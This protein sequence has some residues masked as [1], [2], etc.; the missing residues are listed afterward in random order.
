[1]PEGDTIHYAANRIRPV[2]EGRIPEEIRTPQARHRMDRWPERLAGREVEAVEARGKHLLIRFAGELTIHSHLRMTGSWGVYGVGSP[3]APRAAPRLARD[4]RRGIGGRR[5]R[6]AGPRA[7]ERVAG[8]GR[9]PPEEA[10][11][12]RDRLRTSTSSCSCA[13]CAKTIPTRPIGDALLD[14]R[15]LAGI[16]NLW[17]AESCFAAALDPWRCDGRGERRGGHARPSASPASRWPRSAVEGFMA[18]PR[19]VYRRA[20]LPCPRCGGA[21]RQLRPGR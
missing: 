20:G 4:P 14:Q 15:T 3:V 2:L 11:A 12:G 9:P 6:R 17:K 21:I 1:M 5:V 19:A 7:V 8:Q 10:G 18:R 16:G 13:G